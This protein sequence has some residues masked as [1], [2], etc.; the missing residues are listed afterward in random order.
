MKSVLSVALV[1]IACSPTVSAQGQESPRHA[2]FVHLSP[3]TGTAVRL[4][5]DLAL[6]KLTR[7]GCADVYGDFELP[8]GSTPRAVLD[9]M[10]MRPEEFLE[11]LVFID[12]SAD[13]VCRNG[14][15]ALT[16]TPGSHV[17]YVCPGFAQFQLRNRDLSASLIIHESLH[18]LGLGE[19]PPSSAEITRRVQRRC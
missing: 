9:R 1:L 18:V 16:A 3:F 10:R 5:I 19:N 13:H 17:I 15:A 2:L 8:D 7:P 12:G 4:A 11:S 14:L 6:S